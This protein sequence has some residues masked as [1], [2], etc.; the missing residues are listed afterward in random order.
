MVGIWATHCTNATVFENHKKMSHFFCSWKK[1]FYNPQKILE[2]KNK[3]LKPKNKIIEPKN[4]ILEP[5]NRI[6]EP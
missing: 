6:L 1:K 2:P 3:I 4:K 5:K